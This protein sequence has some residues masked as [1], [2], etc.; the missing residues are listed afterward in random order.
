MY[1]Q[2][3]GLFK[4]DAACFKKIRAML[5]T[6]RVATGIKPSSEDE[7]VWNRGG[8]RGTQHRSGIARRLAAAGIPW[9]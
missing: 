7:Y 4:P 8:G 9:L 3:N 6:V 1:A 5:T 2:S